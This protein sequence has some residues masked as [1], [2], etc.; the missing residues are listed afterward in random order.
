MGSRLAVRATIPVCHSILPPVDP[1]VEWVPGILGWAKYGSGDG[2]RPQE[3]FG[4]DLSNISL[5]LGRHRLPLKK[6]FFF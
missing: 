5:A 2:H 4:L 6:K 1:A 3:D